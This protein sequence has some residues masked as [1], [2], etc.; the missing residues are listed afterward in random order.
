MWKRPF[1]DSV[2]SP[3]PRL[4]LRRLSR[5]RLHITSPQPPTDRA[6][7]RRVLPGCFPRSSGD[8]WQH[9][10]QTRHSGTATETIPASSGRLYLREARLYF[11]VSRRSVSLFPAQD[12]VLTL[13]TTY[14]PSVCFGVSQPR[15]LLHE[16]GVKKPKLLYSHDCIVWS[17]LRSFN[18]PFVC[19]LWPRYGRCLLVCA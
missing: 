3:C 5:R 11:G 16:G 8:R 10:L 4:M 6:S 2:L 15:L 17:G 9:T 7:R 12:A 13:S 18:W 19:S 1:Y 14:N